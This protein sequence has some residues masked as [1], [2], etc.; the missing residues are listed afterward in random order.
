MHC[1]TCL[2]KHFEDTACLHLTSRDTHGGHHGDP[3]VLEFHRASALEGG[4]VTIRRKSDGVPEAHR[5]LHSELALECSQ[6]R[7]GVVCPVTPSG[8]CKAVLPQE[9]VSCKIKQKHSKEIDLRAHVVCQNPHGA[10]RGTWLTC[11]MLH[12]AWKN[13]PMMAIMASLPFASSADNFLVFSAGSEEVS[14]LKP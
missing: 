4:H 5:I 9:Q 12:D 3:S 6:R 1:C 7:G 11:C 10:N 8:S 2:T 13:M 14:T